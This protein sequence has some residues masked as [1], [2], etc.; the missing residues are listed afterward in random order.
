MSDEHTSYNADPYSTIASNIIEDRAAAAHIE[1]VWRYIDDENTPFSSSVL[2]DFLDIYTGVI[3]R[4]LEG[5]GIVVPSVSVYDPRAIK[6]VRAALRVIYHAIE[7]ISVVLNE[8]AKKLNHDHMRDLLMEYVGAVCDYL[9]T[10]GVRQTLQSLATPD[11]ADAF[12]R[13]LNDYSPGERPYY[14]VEHV[15]GLR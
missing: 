14:F 3:L 9:E 2:M 7:S 4:E 1:F 11:A 8:K 12:K 6:E 5:R 13:A 10:S 15:I